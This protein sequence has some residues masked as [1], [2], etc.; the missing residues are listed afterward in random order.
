MDGRRA[1]YGSIDGCRAY[2]TVHGLLNEIIDPSQESKNW[3]QSLFN[4]HTRT[5]WY[6]A[7]YDGIAYSAMMVHDMY[8]A[9]CMA[10]LEVHRYEEK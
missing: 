3:C 8:G 4:I 5:H 6:I 10:H 1:V 2:A 9:W 7:Y